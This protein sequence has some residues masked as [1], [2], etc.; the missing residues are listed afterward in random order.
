MLLSDM[1]GND[2]ASHIRKNYKGIPIIGMSG[3]P[4][5]IEEGHF[6]AIVLKPFS[7][8]SLMDTVGS[9]IYENPTTH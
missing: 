5:L 9:L 1:N 2:V 7:M 6:D 8:K 4:W 3:T